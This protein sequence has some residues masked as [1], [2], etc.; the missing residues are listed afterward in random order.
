[1]MMDFVRNVIS[2]RPGLGGDAPLFLIPQEIKKTA[3]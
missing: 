3:T 1:M 2:A